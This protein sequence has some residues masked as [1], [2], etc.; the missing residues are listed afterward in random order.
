MAQPSSPISLSRRTMI[1]TGLAGLTGAAFPVLAAHGPLPY[2]ATPSARQLAWQKMEFYGFLHFT[3]NTF[4]DRDWGLGDEDPAVFNP[5]DFDAD[6]IVSSGKAAGMKQLILTAKHH[7][8]FCLWP[9]RLTEHCIRNSPFERG[10][11]DIVRDIARACARHGLGFGV[12][13]S[14]W[15]RNHAEYGRPAY[16]EYYLAQ[17]RELLTLYGPIQEVWFDGANGGDGFY[18][19]AYETREIDGATYY[20]WPEIYALVRRLQPQAVMFRDYG[21]DVRW[22]GNEAG[23]AGDPCWPTM[24]GAPFTPALGNE[25]V[26]GGSL[27]NP[28]E[29][30]VSVRHSWFWH[31]DENEQVRSPANLLKLYL[32]SV[33]RGCCLLLNAPPDRR[34]RIDDADVAVL[35]DFRA[36]L[37]GAFSRNFAARAQI[38][39]SSV[40]GPGFEPAR[41]AAGGSWAAKESDRAGA[42]LQLD[43]PEPATF[44]LIRLREDTPYGVRVDDYLVEIEQG[45]DW[46][47]LARHSCIGA[48]RIIRLD[49]PVTAQ[50]VRLRVLAA[51]ASPVISEFGLFRLPEIVEDPVIARDEQGLVTLT[52]PGT[53]ADL[54]YS[55]DGSTP[56]VPYAAPIKWAGGGRV[57]AQ[58]R[59]R[60]GLASAVITVDYDIVKSGWRIVSSNSD[61]AKALLSWDQSP[62]GDMCD[63]PPGQ[64]LDVVIDLGRTY[65]ATGFT[66]QRGQWM[67]YG[68]A[69]PESCR[70]W[71]SEDG[72]AWGSPV[73]ETELAALAACRSLQRLPFAHPVS[74]RYLRVHLPRAAGGKPGIS[75]ARVGI[76]TA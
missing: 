9:S 52:V 57:R 49:A 61:T 53:G 45:R 36:L 26:R 5:T 24:S 65:V 2:G 48:Q 75:L 29:V 35:K 31:A 6:Q 22:V 64:P 28:A 44:D 58:A 21:T 18:G 62:D 71:L 17:L 38:S 23:V 19:G 15:D 51:R 12:Y 54:F 10:K 33:G 34:G 70:V 30:D 66:I 56:S 67:S 32:T 68:G 7:D 3:V 46:R 16:V 60:S 63:A 1:G 43:L 42:W 41:L 59:R 13:L 27:W 40:F 74:G 73:L 47:E 50:K 25:G 55:L 37:D 20:R 8:G 72:H 39:A 69:A 4:T 76:T 11:G 14:P